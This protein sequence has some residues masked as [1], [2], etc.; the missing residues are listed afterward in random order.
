MK[1]FL[2][3]LQRCALF[4]GIMTQDLDTL[5]R[6][7]GG[8]VHSY[9]K[10]QIIWQEG[11]RVEHI[12][13]V[14]TGAVQLIREDYDGNRSIMG[15]IGPAQLFGETY[16]YAEVKALPVSVMAC[17]DSAV[18][19]V[20][21]HRICSSCSNACDFHNRLIENLLHLTAQKN[22]MLHQKIHITSKRTTREKLMAYL[23]IQAKHHG[24]NR[25]TIPF[26]RQALADYLEVD[27]SG[28]SAE[29]SK[30]RREGVLESEK[31]SFTLLT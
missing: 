28:L 19:L 14:L 31:N 9:K 5:L 8:K 23:N 17:A 16:A 3:I 22:L 18:L 12:G 25:F 24:S 6:C 7:L 30:L 26:D 2:Q 1:E 27:R 4:R 15:H 10:D 29:I 11:D 21:S 13:I 20:D